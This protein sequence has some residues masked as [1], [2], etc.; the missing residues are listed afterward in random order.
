MAQKTRAQLLTDIDIILADNTTGDI[1]ASDFRSILTDMKDSFLTV[2][3]DQ[4]PTIKEA[5]VELTEA[6]VKA[7]NTTPYSLVP[8]PGVGKGIQLLGFATRCDFNSIAYATY[9]TLQLITDTCGIAQG[10]DT[11]ILVSTASRKLNGQLVLVSGIGGGEATM[12]ENKALMVTVQ[13]GDPTAGNSR[14][15]VYVMYRIITF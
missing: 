4:I 15:F 2:L 5:W 10:A 6:Q 11:E 12:A 8:A 3:D 9:T 13:D 7:L 1:D 14:I